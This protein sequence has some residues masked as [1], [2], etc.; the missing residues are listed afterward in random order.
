MKKYFNI[1]KIAAV[2]LLVFP[3]LG[4]PVLLE[5]L[6]VII[7]GAL[8]GITTVFIENKLGLMRHENPETSLQEYVQEL[9]E[10]FQQHNSKIIEKNKTKTS[11][12]ISD[13]VMNE[14]HEK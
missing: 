4:L 7:L 12:R 8:V 3:F 5:N 10:K 13:M 11:N 6:Y 1:I 2:L 14:D 9:K